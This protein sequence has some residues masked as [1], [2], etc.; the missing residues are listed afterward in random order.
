[1][2]QVKE[3]ILQEAQRI[4][5]KDR[6]VSHGDFD[7]NFKTAAAMFTA[8]TG[9]TLT[10]PQVAQVII[11]LKQARFRHNPKYRDNLV[12]IAGYTELLSRMQ[13]KG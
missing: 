10:A 9:I 1:M 12:D 5:Y 4:V 8:W 2:I 13:E 6:A 11:C 3:S 7:D